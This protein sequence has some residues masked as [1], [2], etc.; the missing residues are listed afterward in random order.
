MTK[1]NAILDLSVSA[2]TK[3]ANK[4]LF[5][6][7][8]SIDFAPLFEAVAKKLQL[9]TSLEFD[10]PTV[11][12]QGASLHVNCRSNNIVSHAGVFTAIMDEVRI[13]LASSC[14]RWEV[15]NKWYSLWA[16]VDFTYRF[17]KGGQSGNELAAVWYND[18]KGWMI[19]FRKQD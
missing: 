1:I 18:K 14:I 10:I 13:V 3:E 4:G 19:N 12:A 2:E 11:C 8:T 5:A 6:F 15:E 17:A 7:G 9:S 16:C